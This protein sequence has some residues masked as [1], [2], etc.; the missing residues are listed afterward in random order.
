MRQSNWISR[1]ASTIGKAYQHSK[2]PAAL[3]LVFIAAVGSVLTSTAVQVAALTA[4]CAILVEVLFEIQR[5]TIEH[6]RPR[7]FD[8][9]YDVSLHIEEQIQ[10]RM[11]RTRKVQ[12]RAIGMSMGHAW[13]FLSE[14]LRKLL[15]SN[16]GAINLHLAIIDSQWNELAQVNPHWGQ[17]ADGNVARISTFAEAN[18]S[19]LLTSG[20]TITIS[21]YAHMPN[22]HGVLLDDDVLFESTCIWQGDTLAGAENE[23]ERHVVSDPIGAARIGRFTSWFGYNTRNLA[24]RWPAAPPTE[25]LPSTT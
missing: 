12:I 2:R 18:I 24:Q 9:F 16:A 14:I 23:Y 15:D 11:K 10:Q 4:L 5:Y 25:A 7:S 6:S 19:R 8:N 22:W 13:P 17:T 21:R 20:S 1:T 3:A